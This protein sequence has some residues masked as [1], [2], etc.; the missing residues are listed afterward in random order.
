[1]KVENYFKFKYNY[2]IIF[3]Q[4]QKLL[5]YLDIINIKIFFNIKLQFNRQRVIFSRKIK[6]RMIK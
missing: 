1:M 3:Y 5:N 2:K 6:D 4:N